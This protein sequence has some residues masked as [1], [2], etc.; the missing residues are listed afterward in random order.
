M[1]QQ[2]VENISC[3]ASGKSNAI[4][5]K[6]NAIPGMSNATMTVPFFCP[7][8]FLLVLIHAGPG[9]R[10]DHRMLVASYLLTSF[11]YCTRFQDYAGAQGKF[12]SGSA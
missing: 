6:S 9:V 8:F 11:V 4:P 1:A 10:N 7:F 3:Q 2:A 12:W 5:G